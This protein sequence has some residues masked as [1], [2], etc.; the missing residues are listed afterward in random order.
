[1]KKTVLAIGPAS[2]YTNLLAN[3]Q[4][5]LDDLS[6]FKHNNFNNLHIIQLGAGGTGGYVAYEI[7]RMLGNIPEMLK[8]YVHYTLMDGDVYEPKNLG[9]QL[10][11]ED[12]IGKYKAQVLVEDYGELFGVTQEQ[13]SHIDEYFTDISQLAVLPKFPLPIWTVFVD[14]DVKKFFEDSEAA[15]AFNSKQPHI[16]APATSFIIIDCVDKNAPRKLLHDYFAD[17]DSLPGTLARLNYSLNAVS[18]CDKITTTGQQIMAHNN[19]GDSLL[20]SMYGITPIRDIY[21][22][23]S[24]NGK[25]TGQVSWGRKSFLGNSSGPMHY[26]DIF[27]DRDVSSILGPKINTEGELEA[28][29]ITPNMT[30]A[31]VN[32]LRMEALAKYYFTP[33][34]VKRFN[35]NVFQEIVDPATGRLSQGYIK[36]IPIPMK[37]LE[38]PEIE[39][40]HP[41]LK[42][43]N[44]FMSAFMSTPTPYD[45]FPSLTDL[46]IDKREEAMSCAERAEHNVQSIN[47]NKTAAALVVNYFTSIFNGMYMFEKEVPVLTTETT[48]FNILT[49]EYSSDPIDTHS[50]R[51]PVTMRERLRVQ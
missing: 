16:N 28:I 36:S 26:K 35:D 18:N 25:Y 21:I 37:N 41:M 12:D 22:I 40:K 10:C 6:V 42:N 50:L 1:M 48:R 45:R 30:D 51:T 13:A 15:V 44:M 11:C 27:G 39:D 47:A 5:H 7:L 34:N 32:K 31:D 9:R 4:E 14:N 2:P 24:G 8:P 23:S 38:D 46:E 49:G 19:N 33:S 20:G 3:I 17:I 43:M 29:D